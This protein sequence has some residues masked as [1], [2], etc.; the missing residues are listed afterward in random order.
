VLE[1]GRTFLLIGAVVT[2]IDFAAYY[3]LIT[4]A[5]P[6]TAPEM[7]ILGSVVSALLY[8][9]LALRSFGRVY[10]GLFFLATLSALAALDVRVDAQAG[11]AFVP[12]VVLAVLLQL[13][14]DAKNDRLARVS[15]PLALP[16]RFLAAVAALEGV[17]L[18][19]GT[20]TSG[21]A[22]TATVAASAAYYAIRARA[23]VDWERWLVVVGPGA[24]AA[25]AVHDVHGAV[26][27]YGFVFASLAIAYGVAG[28]IAGL[29]APV[30]VAA[31]VA[32]RCRVVSLVAVAGAML[33][34]PSYWRAPL[35]GTLVNLAMAAF[36]AVVAVAR[37]RRAPGIGGAAK[38]DLGGHVLAGALALHLGVLF[39]GL[40]SGV[41]T[42]GIGLFSGMS[43]RDL[44]IL[45]APVA[46]ALAIS[47][48]AARARAA[49]L[50]ASAA[51]AALISAALVVVLAY[52][53]PPL[54]TLF[55]ALACAGAV[56][57]ALRSGRPRGLWIAAAF[58]A[59]AL[60]GL[61]RWTGSPAEW[62]PLSLAAIALA[63]FVP[64]FIRLR[65]NEFGRVSREIA[66]V[67]AAT[68]VILGL[69]AAAS[70]TRMTDSASWLTT[71]PALLVFGCLGVVESLDRRSERG[72]LAATTCFL[73]VA[74][75]L[76]ARFRP[77]PAEAY[78]WPTA[79]YLAAVAWGI[80]RFASD[81]LRT[82]LLVPAQVSAAV[83]LMGSSLLAMPVRGEVTRAAL[84]MG[85]AVVV[86][87]YA[88][89]RGSTPL[90]TTALGFLAAML[91]L[92]SISPLLLETTSAVFGA[93][94]IGLALAV[95]RLVPW[96]LSTRWLE[97]TEIAGALLVA[98]PPLARASSGASD[99]L[100]H[101][102]TV[103]AAGWVI[104]A[105]AVWGGR[106]ALL[107]AALG[108]LA[109]AGLLALRD[110]VRTEPYVAGAGV[111]LLALA[112]ASPRFLPRRLPI[113]FEWL[114]ESVAVVLIVSGA[115]ARTFRDGGDAPSRAIA[116][117]LTLVALG[118]IAARP[119]LTVAALAAVGV[120]A[121]WIVGDPRA[122][123]FH[124]IVA[125]AYLMAVAFGAI[126]YAHR[127]ID[128]RVLLA[129]ETGGAFLFIVPTLVAGWGAAFFPQTVMVFVEIF[130]VMGIGIVLHRRWLVAAALAALGLETIRG[131][132]DA[133]NRLP[134]WALFGATGA[135]L[136][137]VGFVLL[138]KREE[139]NAWSRSMF[140]WWSRL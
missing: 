104:A 120:L 43:P 4:R 88:A 46:A 77:D 116:E 134:N 139:W 85:E 68:A 130:L 113:R 93:V 28:D 8:A 106:R 123:E 6:L 13:A 40:S 11:W 57:G 35:V 49:A 10:A 22:L 24:T 112:F 140:R 56:A 39:A 26:Q 7:W 30:R 63:L 118:V 3:V 82:S 128:S 70:H 9:A 74:L 41:L 53:D 55:G 33:P 38:I 71:I 48:A 12:F 101:G 117:S 72:V 27:T 94:L 87:R 122:R 17:V 95:P 52:G 2:P 61:S 109:L 69:A 31:W 37:A 114:M 36:L 59:T 64:A 34:V 20:S 14:A 105:L 110:T 127:R 51:L 97:A 136:L 32:R 84:V 96:K 15:E 79:I 100:D 133:A 23:G 50:E 81:R 21:W 80:A 54:A 75:M 135:I 60:M 25:A 90:A 111:A 78:S 89:G 125:G 107:S 121:T 124:G 131:A 29:G 102:V 65:A 1:A 45:F 44:A 18:S 132:I 99:A 5:S 91:Y 42:G 119:A 58:G 83:V 129:M 76:V 19:V 67:T 138:L 86:L 73:A 98:V 126:R 137:S 92:A 115:L 16:S 62:R 66:L 47:A 108:A 103:L